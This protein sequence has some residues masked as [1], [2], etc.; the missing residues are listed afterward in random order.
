[1]S[2]IAMVT[3]VTAD[4][5]LAQIREL[6]PVLKK[7]AT[8]CESERR[9]PLETVADFKKV[10]LH[11]IGVPT[12][13]GGFD[14]ELD[15]GFAAA[16][17]VG[18][19]CGSS[20]WMASQWPI[21]NFFIGIFPD[22]A[23]REVWGSDPHALSSTASAVK[24]STIRPVEGGYRLS[25]KWAMS[26]GVDHAQWLILLNTGDPTGAVALAL[27]PKSDFK[28]VDDWW[29]MGL[30][31]TGSKTVVIEDAFVPVHRVRSRVEFM[32][33]G[34]KAAELSGSITY[35]C[36]NLVIYPWTLASPMLG[37]VQGMVDEVMIQLPRR[38]NMLTGKPQSAEDAF[39]VR[40]A[41]ASAMADTALLIFRDSM[42]EL[43]TQARS[44]VP[45]A[46]AEIVRFNRNRAFAVRLALQAAELLFDCAGGGALYDSNPIQRLYRDVK[47]ASRHVALNIEESLIPFTADR[48]GQEL[49]VP[50]GAPPPKAPDAKVG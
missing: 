27:I 6:Q 18:R 50:Y 13:F 4:Q 46:R 19:A 7:R 23:Q 8:Q 34:P 47:A 33:S 45:A 10:G 22:Q 21:H 2:S 1:M 31:G 32:T 26:S 40:F 36:P 29:V 14:L 11:L 15:V 49:A 38:R 3:A 12:R 41:E 5:L 17:E 20:A 35:R 43:M 24:E 25:G 16:I 28:I 37:M 9:V 42:N 44:G 30:R 48:F 39:R